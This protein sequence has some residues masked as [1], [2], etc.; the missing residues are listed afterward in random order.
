M[1]QKGTAEYEKAQALANQ[2]VED[3]NVGRIDSATFERKYDQMGRFLMKIEK[4]DVFA[5]QVAK[6]VLKTQ[7]PYGKQVAFLSSKQSWII[8]CSAVENGIEY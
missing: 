5:S 4:L 3:S 6:T 7:N 1:I 2:L 8:A